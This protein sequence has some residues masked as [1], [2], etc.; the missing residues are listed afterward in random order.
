[1]Y[2]NPLLSNLGQL[3]TKIVK[4]LTK[5][6]VNKHIPV[7]HVAKITSALISCLAEIQP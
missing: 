2:S 3:G 1:M 4:R 5:D 6:Q 7:L